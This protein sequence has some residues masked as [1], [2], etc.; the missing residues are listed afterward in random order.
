MGEL[1]TEQ[2]LS[3][4]GVRL[5]SPLGKVNRLAAGERACTDGLSGSALLHAN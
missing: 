1:V 4:F 2:K 5:V 3:C